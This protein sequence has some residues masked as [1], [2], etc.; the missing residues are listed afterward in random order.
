[1]Q[2]GRQISVQQ[3]MQRAQGPTTWAPQASQ[4]ME[5]TQRIK[6]RLTGIE[7][8]QEDR[9]PEHSRHCPEQESRAAVRRLL[10][11]RRYSGAAQVHLEPFAAGIDVNP[12]E[13]LVRFGEVNDA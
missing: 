1:M 7:P 8:K 5:V 11:P 6:G 12:H 3:L 13:L 9:R 2:C 4:P 10:A